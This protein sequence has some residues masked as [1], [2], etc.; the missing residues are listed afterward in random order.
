M[1]FPQPNLL[2][3]DGISSTDA[4]LIY[5]DGGGGTYQINDIYVDSKIRGKGYGRKLLEKLFYAIGTRTK[6]WAITR[7]ENYI[8]QQFY[9]R[10]LFRNVIPLRDFYSN[11]DENHNDTIDAVMYSRYSDG[12]V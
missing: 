7:A 3:L 9:E 8:A 1:K 12:P 10:C 5:S 11:K 6:V 4:Y 2:A